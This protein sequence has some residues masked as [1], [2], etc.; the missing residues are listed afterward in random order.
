MHIIKNIL[1]LIAILILPLIAACCSSDKAE[2]FTKDPDPEY[3]KEVTF[4]DD[5]GTTSTRLVPVNQVMVMLAED[6]SANQISSILK[7]M[8]KDLKN[9]GL[10]L[11]GQVPDLGIYQFEIDNNATDPQEAIAFLDTVVESLQSYEGVDTV[12]YNEL[13]ESRFVENDD[14]NCGYGGDLRCPFAAIDYYQAIPVFDKVLQPEWLNNVTVAV[15]D[16]GLWVATGQFDDILPRTQFPDQ[17]SSS[18]EPY[19]WHPRKHGTTVASIIVADNGDGLN[20]GIASRILGDRLHLIVGDAHIALNYY[21]LARTISSARRAIELG[22]RVINYSMGLTASCRTPQSLTQLQNQFMRLFTAPASANVL[23]VASASNDRLVLNNNDAPAGLPAPNLITVG[24]LESCYFNQRYAFSATG[25][26]IDIAAPATYIPLCCVGDP[27]VGPSPINEDGNSFAA[28]I[29][30]AMAAIV[31]SI[32]PEFTGAE[33]KNFLIDVDHVW[34]AP[35]EVGGKRVALIKTV[36][37][38][39]LQYAPSSSAVDTIMDCFGVSSDDIPDPSGHMINRLCGEA[40]FSVVGPG[41]SQQHSMGAT[42]LSFSANG[43]NFGTIGNNFAVFNFTGGDD[44]LSGFVNSSLRLNQVYSIT[45]GG[46]NGFAIKAGAAGGGTYR[47]SSVSGTFTFTECELTTRSLPLD[48]FS[49]SN[50]GADQLVFIEVAGTLGPSSAVGVIDRPG[51]EVRNVIY[52]VTGSF[53]TA[54]NLINPDNETLEHLEQVCA[55]GYQY[56]P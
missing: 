7:K 46:P 12:S 11:V 40:E 48:W 50:P 19:D 52:S 36:G 54:F 42:D 16:S 23:F 56:A 45:E 22:A 47:G 4:I 30:S 3:I 14:D 17:S 27:V 9:T 20:N 1:T 8:K 43:G 55:G 49:P 53:T 18:P 34:P 31:L 29:V 44:V 15:I 39:I 13:L 24:G 32:H 6:L 51:E 25:P 33:L 28:P 35:E 26:G 10:T 38:A 37:S 21:S 5:D 2:I 41:Y